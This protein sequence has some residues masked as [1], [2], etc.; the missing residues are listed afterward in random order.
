MVDYFEARNVTP[1]TYKNYSVPKYM[2][3]ILTQDKKSFVL[4]FGC[5]FGQLIRSLADLGCVNIYGAD[6]ND[7]ALDYCKSQGLRVEDCKNLENI[8]EKYKNKFDLVIMSH[9]LEHI[10]KEEIIPFLKKIRLLLRPTGGILIMVPNAQSNTNCYWAYEDF[11]H[12]TL[13]TSGSI[14]YVL[15]MAGFKE[16]RF[17]DTDCTAGLPYHKKILRK[18]LMKIFY[19]RVE[20]WNRVTSSSFHKPS[21]KIYSYEIKVLA[22]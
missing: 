15:K 5:G 6:I 18:L 17:V 2:S 3:E 9:V 21:P 14:F 12:T 20:F 1:E 16:I 11:T 13:F 19:F 22:K 7:Q 10:T 8:V 4:D